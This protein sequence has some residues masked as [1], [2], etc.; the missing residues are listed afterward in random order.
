M[1]RAKQLE[2]KPILGCELE[3]EEGGHLILLVKDWSGYQSG[4]FT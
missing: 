1:I 4:R 3:L 2:I